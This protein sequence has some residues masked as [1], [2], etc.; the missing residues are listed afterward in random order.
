MATSGCIDF[1]YLYKTLATNQST[2]NCTIKER[3]STMLEQ[4]FQAVAEQLKTPKADFEKNMRA[5]LSDTLDRM[6]IVS[7][8]TF[9]N[10]EKQLTEAKKAIKTLEQQ[11]DAL[12]KALL[13]NN[14]STSSTEKPTPEK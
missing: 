8:D 6:D 12:E 1:I 14:I 11:V 10:Q 3:D 5:W 9:L 4:F 7:R 13:H 2:K